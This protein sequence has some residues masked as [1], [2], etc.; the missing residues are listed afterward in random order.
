MMTPEDWYRFW[1]KVDVGPIDACW[2]W[3]GVKNQHGYG[4]FYGRS[5]GLTAGSRR[6][7]AH[8]LAYA[9]AHGF[10]YKKKVVCHRC[11]NPACV[12]PNHLFLGTML[13]NCRDRDRKGRK[14]SMR[15]DKNPRTTLT[16]ED[17]LCIRRE[18]RKGVNQ[19]NTG[20]RTQLALRY[21]VSNATINQVI[22]GRT[23]A[24]LPLHPE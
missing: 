19:N 22:A 24:H 18:Y 8:R 16:E 11:D 4:K 3:L 7:F 5:F 15:G 10:F 21:G 13:D 2:E 17:V 6:K 14:A 12:N 20:N 1:S 9:W 23:W